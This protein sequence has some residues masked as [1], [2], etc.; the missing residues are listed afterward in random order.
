MRAPDSI[1]FNLVGL[2]EDQIRAYAKA[3][4]AAGI[5]VQVFGLSAD[6]ARAFWNWDFLPEKFELPATRAMLMT[7]CD[8]R[9]PA[10]LTLAECDM[11]ADALLGAMETVMTP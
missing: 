4:K 2:T 5:T 1:Q 11:V 3:T 7:A 8:A 6:N 9:L 10:R